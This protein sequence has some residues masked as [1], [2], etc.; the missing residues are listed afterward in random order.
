[1]SKKRNIAVF[2]FCYFLV[3]FY[4]T[5]PWSSLIEL[6]ANPRLPQFFFGFVAVTLAVSSGL[7]EGIKAVEAERNQREKPEI[8]L[9]SSVLVLLLGAVGFASIITAIV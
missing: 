9:K 5:Y 8:T 2:W 1:M 6:M 3:F 4:F 7:S